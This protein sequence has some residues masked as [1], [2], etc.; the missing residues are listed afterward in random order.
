MPKITY[1]QLGSSKSWAM[2]T[3]PENTPMKDAVEL[4]LPIDTYPAVRVYKFGTRVDARTSE[5]IVEKDCHLTAVSNVVPASVYV[6]PRRNTYTVP[7]KPGTR[8]CDLAKY[9]A[10]KYLSKGEQLRDMYDPVSKRYRSPLNMTLPIDCLTHP[11]FRACMMPFTVNCMCDVMENWPYKIRSMEKVSSDVFVV[12]TDKDAGV[13]DYLVFTGKR[14]PVV[15][16]CPGNSD[17]DT[18]GD[19]GD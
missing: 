4:L 1:L 3:V 15:S 11:D 16:R 19:S 14:F 2:Q 7:V 18:M 13:R 9:F 5:D 12:K 10:R 6:E 8:V 17:D